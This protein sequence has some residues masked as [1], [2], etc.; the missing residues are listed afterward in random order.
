MENNI[1]V[2]QVIAMSVNELKGLSVPVALIP[3]LGNTIANVVNN[4][5]ICLKAINEAEQKESL[6]DPEAPDKN[7]KMVPVDEEEEGH[8]EKD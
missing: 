7:F 3:T 4:L 5:G 8:D 1:T 6:K 2:K